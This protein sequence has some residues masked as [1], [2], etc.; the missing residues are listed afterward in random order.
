MPWQDASQLI[1]S[2][3]KLHHLSPSQ[4]LRQLKADPEWTMKVGV[5]G[6]LYALTLVLILLNILSFPFVLCLWA[7][8]QGYLITTMHVALQ[9]A[10]M[11]LPRWK[12]FAELLIAG[13]TWMAI[14]SLQWIMLFSII[15]GALKI[16]DIIHSDRLVAS[17]FNYWAIS[18]WSFIML[19]LAITS[20]FSAYRLANFAALQE[21][22]AAFDY[23]EVGK[24]FLRR[25]VPMLQAWLLQAGRFGMAIVVP[26]ATIVGVF[27]LPT[28]V[29][30]AQI[31][32]V[33]LLA[34]AWEITALAEKP[35]PNAG[36]PS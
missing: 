31:L 9:D 25:P 27:L 6:M 3:T 26:I 15:I 12:T 13:L 1:D 17:S 11:P 10:H 16:S 32:G 23:V 18:A 28:T 7:I 29:F 19:L 34:Q 5:G 8:V 20:F 30:I 22:N 2:K 33:R 36:Q 4:S 14:E 21:I 35:D 24:R